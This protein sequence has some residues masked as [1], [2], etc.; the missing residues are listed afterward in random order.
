MGSFDFLFRSLC[1]PFYQMSRDRNDLSVCDLGNHDYVSY[2]TIC[3]HF[4]RH[5][6]YSLF[7]LWFENGRGQNVGIFSIENV[8]ILTKALWAH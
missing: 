7:G 5:Q 4:F 2:E 1:G 8:A 3:G 6:K